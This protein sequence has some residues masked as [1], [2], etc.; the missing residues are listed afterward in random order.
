[1]VVNKALSKC[2]TIH[3]VEYLQGAAGS[4]TQRLTLGGAALKNVH[5][6]GPLAMIIENQFYNLKFKDEEWT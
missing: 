5:T 2:T 6:H 3:P 4:M 1:M